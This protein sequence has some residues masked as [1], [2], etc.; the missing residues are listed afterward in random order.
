MSSQSQGAMTSEGSFDLL[1]QS[2]Q[3]YT[4]G[5]VAR[6]GPRS[7]GSHR[8]SGTDEQMQDD[9]GA[10]GLTQ[11]P[12]YLKGELRHYQIEGV[13]W[14]IN[15]FDSGLNGILADEMGLGKT[16][17]TIA[18]LGYLKKSRGIPGPHLVVCP[19]SICMNWYGVLCF[20]RG[21]AGPLHPQGPSGHTHPAVVLIDAG[22][23]AHGP[24]QLRGR[25][26]HRAG[27]K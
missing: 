27:V 8:H 12:P 26:S 14:L 20:G 7:K 9:V 21:P 6:T 1:M 5:S 24:V 3:A 25:G 11:T 10:S 13:N 16:F 4:Q 15:L 19:L 17:Q 2:V 18:L 22:H 23:R